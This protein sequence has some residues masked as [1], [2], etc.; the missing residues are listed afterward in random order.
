MMFRY[1]AIFYTTIKKLSP[2]EQGEVLRAAME[3][4]MCGEEPDGLPLA[5]E[6]VFDIAK[7]QIDAENEQRAAGKE[8]G[9]KGGRPKKAAVSEEK[10]SPFKEETPSFESETEQEE[11]TDGLSAEEKTGWF[12]NNNPGVFENNPPFSSKK[13]GGFENKTENNPPLLDEKPGGFEQEKETEKENKKERSKERNK[14]KDK[15]KEYKGQGQ[16]INSLFVSYAPAREEQSLEEPKPGGINYHGLS[17]TDNNKRVLTDLL[18]EECAQ[19]A[20]DTAA[21]DKPTAIAEGRYRDDYRLVLDCIPREGA[22][23][24]ACL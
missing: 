9:K 14:E 22:A 5:A 16:E 19:M 21:R 10:P 24:Y 11:T 8:N 7:A 15:E 13:P 2:A 1:P 12:L 3:Y 23:K 6:I 4:S 17:L 20:L 18:G